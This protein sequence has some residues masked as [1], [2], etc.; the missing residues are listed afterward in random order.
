MEEED[1]AKEEEIKDDDVEY[2]E[3]NDS[4]SKNCHTVKKK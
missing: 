2:V 1:E 3:E 4:K